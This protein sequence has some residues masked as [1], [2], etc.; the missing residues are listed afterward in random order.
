M[1]SLLEYANGT[2]RKEDF[3]EYLRLFTG[4]SIRDP[5]RSI[6]ECNEI[7]DGFEQ[8]YAEPISY[9]T[10]ADA[11]KWLFVQQRQDGEIS[12]AVCN[13]MWSSLEVVSK[14]FNP[15]E[16]KTFLE[17]KSYFYNK[18]NELEDWAL[19][20]SAD[21]FKNVWEKVASGP[22]EVTL[23]KNELASLIEEAYKEGQASRG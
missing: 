3:L 18:K 2:V 20:V 7:Y 8:K 21:F 19:N 12:D 13:A 10:F 14:Q 11:Y 15:Q 16:Q 1:T 9:R 5:K 17:W 6:E 4:Y 23:S 22:D